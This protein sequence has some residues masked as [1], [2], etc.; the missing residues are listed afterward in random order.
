VTRVARPLSPI[1]P[2][3]PASARLRGEESTV[4]VEAWVDEV[5]EVAF[6]A[7]LRS[8][9]RDFDSSAERAVRR[10]AFRPAESGGRRVPSRV[11]LRVHFDLHD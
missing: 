8:G 5:G 2:S 11:A 4:V 9:G 10:A 1:L 3:Y 6:A 7:I